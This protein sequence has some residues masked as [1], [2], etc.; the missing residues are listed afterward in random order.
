MRLAF[1]YHCKTLSKLSDYEGTYADDGEPYDDALLEDWVLRHRHGLDT[2]VDPG[3]TRDAHPGGRIFPFKGRDIE[4]HEGRFDGVAVP[5]ANEVEQ[6][7][8][9]LAKVGLEIA[10]LKDELR[11]DAQKCFVKHS[12]PMYPDRPC[13]DYHSDAKWLGRKE[14]IEGQTINVQQGY[15][16]SHCPYEVAVS[17]V[18][19]GYN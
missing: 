11:D 2:N 18:R 19:R 4:I 17:I 13:I 7:R 15:L 3:T 6:V 10:D 12:R 8:A 14:R 16:C 9:E 5:V 1:C